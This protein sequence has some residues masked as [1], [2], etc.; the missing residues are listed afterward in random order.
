MEIKMTRPS[1]NVTSWLALACA[2]GCALD[3]AGLIPHGQGTPAV[4]NID[5]SQICAWAGDDP[6]VCQ[7]VHKGR[8]CPRL[9][10]WPLK[11]HRGATLAALVSRGYEARAAARRAGSAL[12]HLLSLGVDMVRFGKTSLPGIVAAQ[13]E[14]MQPD[15]Y[16]ASGTV[17]A[18]DVLASLI[19]SGG[20][21]VLPKREHVTDAKESV[22]GWRRGDE[23][24]EAAP[25]QVAV[26]LWQ[27]ILEAVV[28][29]ALLFAVLWLLLHFCCCCPCVSE[30]E[31]GAGM[32]NKVTIGLGWDIRGAEIDVDASVVIF[33][34]RGRDELSAVY[35]GN[36][37][38]PGVV[39][40]GDNLTGEGDGDDE[41]ISITFSELPEEAQQLF[42]CITL[43]NPPG[44][45]FK[46]VANAYCK[47]VHAGNNKTLSSYNFGTSS[48]RESGLIMARFIKRGDGWH[49]EKVGRFQSGKDYRDM[50]PALLEMRD[51]AVDNKRRKIA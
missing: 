20:P 22:I 45:T 27:Y 3:I 16:D 51:A 43:Y 39:H 46:D 26:A 36:K 8:W 40:S 11:D 47:I 49:I 37:Q 21:L 42:V 28:L 29:Y 30:E 13:R 25:P 12:G 5:A 15:E 9:L 14:K 41:Q 19:Q 50:L 38:A 23:C 24:E 7:D 44:S 17:S 4:E 1:E 33:D 10:G 48:H 6:S 31:S 2:L 34:A 32:P 35:F 18:Q